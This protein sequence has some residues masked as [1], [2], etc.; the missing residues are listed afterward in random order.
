[1]FSLLLLVGGGAEDAAPYVD[2]EVAAGDDAPGEGDG[3]R[4][5]LE[6]R[7]LV[8]CRG[9]TLSRAAEEGRGARSGVE[10]GVVPRDVAEPGAAAALLAAGD[11]VAPKAGPLIGGKALPP[12]PSADMEGRRTGV[13]SGVSDLR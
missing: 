6:E 3:E 5:A 4:E 8:S 9:S 7:R 11:N 12:P 13:L 10:R 1:M 2:G